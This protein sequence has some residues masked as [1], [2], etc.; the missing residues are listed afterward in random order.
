MRGELLAAG[1]QMGG[2]RVYKVQSYSVPHQL[3]HTHCAQREGLRG[4]FIF[5]AFREACDLFPLN[6]KAVN[7][8]VLKQEF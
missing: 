4:A 2:I 8:K 1:R 5:I 7:K 6:F 3:S